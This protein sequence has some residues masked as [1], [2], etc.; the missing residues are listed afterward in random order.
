MIS[1]RAFDQ[2]LAIYEHDRILWAAA[3]AMH[4]IDAERPL[5]AL[6]QVHGIDPDQE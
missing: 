5:R 2:L 6:A 1:D 3:Y 4:Q